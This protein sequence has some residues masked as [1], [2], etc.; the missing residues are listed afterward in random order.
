MSMN[1][2]QQEMI[3]FH[4]HPH[5]PAKTIT[6]L[7]IAGTVALMVVKELVKK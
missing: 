1:V 5:N 3:H 4:A 2:H 7:M 6:V